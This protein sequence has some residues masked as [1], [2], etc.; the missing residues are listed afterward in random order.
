MTLVTRPLPAGFTEESCRALREKLPYVS[1][2]IR[3]V[4]FAEG[5]ISVVVD[6]S[7]GLEA[8]EGKVDRLIHRF[9]EHQASKPERVLHEEPGSP[10]V[11]CRDVSGALLARGDLVRLGDGQYALTGILLDLLDYFDR[12]IQSIGGDVGAQE[13]R[14]PAIIPIGA[15]QRLQY[16]A[17]RPECLNFISRLRED[18]DVIDAFS[19]EARAVTDRVDLAGRVETDCM[20][21]VAICL[22]AFHQ[23]QDADLGA[24][25]RII[26]AAGKCMRYESARMDTLRRLRDFTMREVVCVGTQKEVAAFRARARA[27]AEERLAEWGLR[28]TV[29]TASDLFFTR[30]F[31]GQATFQ[32]A[33]DLKLELR[34]A[35]D[36]G[37]DLA[38]GSLNNHR[39]FIGKGFAIRAG[40][41][42]A[43]SACLAYGLERCVFAFVTQHGLNPAHWPDGVAGRLRRAVVA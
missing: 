30:E 31:A 12:S 11:R 4:A 27:L 7:P 41:E 36:G 24:P 16:L 28:S 37:E 1:S 21:P 38:I 10:G 26:G 42:P 9:A 15:M 18:I 17:S 13:Y 23:L 43:H 22:H 8:L 33:F 14:Y 2:A 6:D 32:K 39:D 25:R 35:L 19:E 34:A 5:S 40:G 29:M 3:D 20:S